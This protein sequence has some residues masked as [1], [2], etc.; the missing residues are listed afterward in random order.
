MHSEWLGCITPT[1]PTW[2][3]NAGLVMFLEYKKGVP[4]CWQFQAYENNPTNDSFSK[5]HNNNKECLQQLTWDLTATRACFSMWNVCIFCTQLD[6]LVPWIWG[7]QGLWLPWPTNSHAKQRTCTAQQTPVF[8]FPP[9][10]Q[11]QGAR[12]LV[13]L[14]GIFMQEL[15]SR[16]CFH[17]V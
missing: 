17:K 7:T 11:G 6:M 5:K 4:L 9:W 3:T 14:T 2:E 15:F 13:L 1:K 8:V 10:Q 12:A 16:G